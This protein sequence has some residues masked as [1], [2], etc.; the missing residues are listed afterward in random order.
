MEKFA[1]AISLQ[2]VKGTLLSDRLVLEICECS[3]RN[4]ALGYVI[5][6]ANVVAL[7]EDGFNIMLHVTRK[8]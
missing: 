7:Q 8:V 3:D 6:S 1:V 5:N 2:R 4:E